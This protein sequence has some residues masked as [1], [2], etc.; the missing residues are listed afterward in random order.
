MKR[1]KR[2]LALFLSLLLLFSVS[3]PVVSAQAPYQEGDIAGTI[4]DGTPENPIQVDTYAEFK[5]ALE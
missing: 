1:T 4:G 2:F 3:M 5:K